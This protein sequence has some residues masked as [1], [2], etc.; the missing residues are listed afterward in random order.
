MGDGAIECTCEGDRAVVG[1]YCAHG[2]IPGWYSDRVRV[3]GGYDELWMY[4]QR[5]KL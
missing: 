3:V 1:G 2:T 5:K 4:D